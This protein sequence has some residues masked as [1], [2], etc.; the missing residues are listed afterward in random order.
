MLEKFN[1]DKMLAEIEAEEQEENVGAPK[2]K[3][4]SQDEIKSLLAKRK[5][6]RNA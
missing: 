1:L 4:L 6:K 5:N 2:N 3:K